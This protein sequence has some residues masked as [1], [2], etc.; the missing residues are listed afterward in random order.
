M[1]PQVMVRPRGKWLR[2]SELP[3]ETKVYINNQV[4]IPALLV[5]RLGI[6]QLRYADIT[7]EY[8]GFMIV[9]RNVRLLRPRQTAARQFTIPRSVREQY[10]IRPFDTIRVVSIEPSG[11][12]HPGG[13]H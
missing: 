6:E 10:G 13:L 8:K 3:Y 9:I 1:A 2:I 12:T 5:R 7:I 11:N 4:L